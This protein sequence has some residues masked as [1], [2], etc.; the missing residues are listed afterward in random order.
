MRKGSLELKVGFFVAAAAAVLVFLVVKAGDFYL[1]PGYSIRLRLDSVNGI[2][3]GS[4]V[5]LAGVPI[6]EVKA[7]RAYRTPEGGTEVEAS[8]YITQGIEIEEDA[9]LRVA[10]MGFLGEKYIQIMPGTPSAK[11]LTSG[12]ILSGKQITGVDDLFDAAHRLI[13]KIDDAADNIHEV[14]ANP[15]FKA[16]MK[17]AFSNADKAFSNV[18]KVALNL[19]EASGDLKDAAKSAKIVMARL[20]DG[21]G[22][23]GKLLKDDK[24][25]KDLELF[26]ADIKK[27]PWKLLKKS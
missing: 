5:R 14:V 20:R 9:E 25:A 26:V 3:K 23:V 15:E 21:E 4:S 19:Q 17:G 2:E 8:A 10:T 12:S 22:T 11:K 7:I 24:I 1:K 6:G 13:G 16:S 27:N 18:D